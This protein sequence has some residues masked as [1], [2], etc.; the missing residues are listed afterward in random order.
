MIYIRIASLSIVACALVVSGCTSVL[1]GN[2]STFVAAADAHLTRATEFELFDGIAFV[3]RCDQP[4]FKKGYGL[5]DRARGIPHQPDAT[6]RVASITKSFTASLI[7]QLVEEGQVELDAPITR[8]LPDYPA[9]TGNIVT[10]HHLLS[11]SSGIPNLFTLPGAQE[12]LRRDNSPAELMAIFSGEPLDFEPGTRYVY[13]N[14]NYDIL[15]AIIEEL[16]GMS[17]AEALYT[18]IIAPLNLTQTGYHSPDLVVPDMVQGYNRQFGQ[19]IPAPY[20]H[21]SAVY[22]A[23]MMYSSAAD[24]HAFNCALD[25][26]QVV[27]DTALLTTA[28]TAQ[29]AGSS[30]GYGQM[31]DVYEIGDRV[32]KST[33]HSG[34]LPGVATRN[35]FF[36]EEQLSIIILGN[37][38]FDDASERASELAFLYFGEPAPPLFRSLTWDMARR[39]QESCIDAGLEFYQSVTSKNASDYVFTDSE[40]NS[41]GYSLLRQDRIPEAIRIFEQNVISYPDSANTHDSLGEAYFMDGQLEEAVKSYTRS[42]QLDPGNTNATDMIARIRSQE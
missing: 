20:F 11:H 25:S 39:I 1:S 26:G 32:L 28:F 33:G 19:Y 37:T 7:L 22:A 21:P 3:S 30:Y 17:Y 4:V 18:R 38:M 27:K 10:I 23:G 8:Y 31:V 40:L 14:S 24:L 41:L 29:V 35:L 42:L 36:P 34:D 6:F 15:G 5:A 9:A 12:A 2:D 13:S 16:T